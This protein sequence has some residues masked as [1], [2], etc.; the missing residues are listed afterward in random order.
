MRSGKGPAFV[1]FDMYLK[2]ILIRTI[3]YG[4]IHYLDFHKLFSQ[5]SDQI[6][7]RSSFVDLL[8]PSYYYRASAH[9]YDRSSDIG[10]NIGPSRDRSQASRERRTRIDRRQWDSRVRSLI[11]VF[12]T[13]H[14]L[15]ISRLRT[16][17]DD[18]LR[19]SMKFALIDTWGFW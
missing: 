8:F 6:V 3:A 4:L 14:I 7:S 5:T 15:H 19:R 2:V 17:P 10:Y 12:L 9:N 16:L 1:S 11:H 18:E 13:P